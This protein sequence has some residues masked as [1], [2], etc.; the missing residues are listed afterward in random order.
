MDYRL[1][2]RRRLLHDDGPG[3]RAAGRGRRGPPARGRGARG[4]VRA[5]ARGAARGR[6][7]RP[8][9]AA[10]PREARRA[11]K[12]LAAVVAALAVG[13]TGGSIDVLKVVHSKLPAVRRTSVPILLPQF[14]PLGGPAPKVY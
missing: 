9:A 6:R 10:G 13:T 11:V 8:V 3:A 5:R 2:A 4:R 7:R 12:L 1:R 14:L